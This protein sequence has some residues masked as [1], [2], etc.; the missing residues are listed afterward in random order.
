MWADTSTDQRLAKVAIKSQ[1]FLV[2]TTTDYA[3]NHSFPSVLDHYDP[4]HH[5]PLSAT[6]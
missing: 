6:H 5:L 3:Y 1:V 4:E 2:L